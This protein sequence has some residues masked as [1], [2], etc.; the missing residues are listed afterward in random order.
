VIDLLTALNV[1]IL[2]LDLQQG[3]SGRMAGIRAMQAAMTPVVVAEQ[4]EVHPVTAPRVVT[5]SVASEEV[6][7]T[8]VPTV[9]PTTMVAGV[10]VSRPVLRGDWDALLQ[11]HFG[12]V[13]QQARAIMICESGGNANAMGPLQ[14][15]GNRPYGLMQIMS[16]PGRPSPEWLLNPENNIAFAASIYRAQG[17]GPWSCKYVLN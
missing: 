6:Q 11:A 13:W 8:V 16:M 5:A 9:V 14:L 4:A 10:S 15:N 12:A 3:Q 17:W 2:T 1:G 7:P